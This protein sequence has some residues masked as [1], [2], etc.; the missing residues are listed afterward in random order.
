MHAG[1]CVEGALG[2]DEDADLVSVCIGAFTETTPA[3][4]EASSTLVLRVAVNASGNVDAVTLLTD[5]P[6]SR[7][8]ELAPV[9]VDDDELTADVK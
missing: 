3:L 8:W 6:V 5:T 1:M 7:P 4:P 2:F 9:L